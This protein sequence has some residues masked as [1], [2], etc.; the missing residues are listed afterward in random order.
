MGEKTALTGADLERRVSLEQMK[1]RRDRINEI[2]EEC[3]STMIIQVQQANFLFH[4]AFHIQKRKLT[5][6]TCMSRGSVLEI[7]T[8]YRNFH[9]LLL[10]LITTF[11]ILRKAQTQ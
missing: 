11:S 8:K 3:P 4:M 1:Q 6:H 9:A 5:C 7:V 10:V 2:R